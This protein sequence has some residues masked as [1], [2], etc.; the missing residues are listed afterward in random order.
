MGIPDISDSGSG[1]A[2]LHVLSS[3]F[4][5]L[6][7]HQWA[8][9]FLALWGFVDISMKFSE[10]AAREVVAWTHRMRLYWRR[11]K[12]EPDPKVL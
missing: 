4:E 11:F 2:L 9:G 8:I 7:S 6:V 3:C 1:G 12:D 10:I 5:L